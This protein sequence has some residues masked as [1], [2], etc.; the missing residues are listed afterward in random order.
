MVRKD[1]A[2]KL[3][4]MDSSKLLKYLA[5][6][7]AFAVAA[8]LGAFVAYF[9]QFHGAL[10][11]DQT[12]WGEFGSFLGGTLGPILSFLALMALVLTVALQ[13]RQLGYAHESLQNSRTELAE[14]QALLKRSADAQEKTANALA[15]QVEYAA[16]SARLG[17][18]SASL[19]IVSEA[20][21][22][23]NKISPE[24]DYS[25]G[26]IRERQSALVGEIMGLTDRVRAGTHAKS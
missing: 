16:A 26:S 15:E 22:R 19:A 9:W 13:S 11:Y 7:V 21:A 14:T 18:L 25:S 8:T 5:L 17:A 6:I 12:R 10:S 1:L 4:A 2:A 20:V 24:Y 3:E 23:A